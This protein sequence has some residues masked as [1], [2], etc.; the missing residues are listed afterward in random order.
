MKKTGFRI[1]PGVALQFAL[2]LLTLA[3]YWPVVG[4][5]F[6]NYDDGL[7]V[8]DNPHVQAGLTLDNIAW[9][10]STGHASNWHPVTWLSHLIDF[11]C[12]GWFAGGHHL[13]NVL[14]HTANTLLLFLLL[15]RLTGSLW[16]CAIVAALFA[17]HPL[18]V[19][20]VAWVAER[21]DLLSL[22]FL[23]LSLS[24]YVG[25]VKQP[26]PGRYTLTLACFA[27]GLMA[28]PMI[29]TLP[30]LLLLLDWW[31]LAR[32]RL[33]ATDAG[34]NPS[35]RSHLWP[36]VCEKLPFF[37]L[38]AAS[39]VVTVWTQ[40][41]TGALRTFHAVPL[42]ARLAN[43]VTAYA[44]YLWKMI[45]PADLAVLYPMPSSWPLAMVLGSALAL[46]GLS[47]FAWRWRTQF[48]WVVVGWCWFV[49][50][51]VPVIGLVQVGEQAMADRYTYLPLIGVFLALTWG[52]EAATVARRG[53][54]LAERS[55]RTNLAAQ[56]RERL[57]L[58]EAGRPWRELR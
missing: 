51:L 26:S 36:L 20:S 53:C 19:E 54:D 27:L 22:F 47:L 32:L 8:T 50:T 38:A 35:P 37:A 31:P 57:E 11:S 13:V 48:P 17:W 58:Y 2:A 44:C 56:I 49:V 52:V 15:R 34:E 9:A 6:V 3:L 30:C 14:F 1:R 41:Q 39:C 24:A 55:G 40:H 25:Y 33:S 42:S 16:R 4:H 28:K 43:T 12:F 10:F 5:D 46:A 23:L 18:H 7:Y 29:V 45:W 21:K